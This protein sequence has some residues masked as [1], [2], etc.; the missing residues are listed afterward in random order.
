MCDIALRQIPGQQT[1]F[2]LSADRYTCS[3]LECENAILPSGTKLCA[4]HGP[5]SADTAVA[6]SAVRAALPTRRFASCARK[7]KR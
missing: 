6:R 7:V 4:L 1:E 5:N 2:C 3:N